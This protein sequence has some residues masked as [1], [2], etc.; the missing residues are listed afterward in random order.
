MNLININFKALKSIFR[1]SFIIFFLYS[2]LCVMAISY[3]GGLNNINMTTDFHHYHS[4]WHEH[5]NLNLSDLSVEIYNKK[6]EETD[7]FEYG[8]DWLPNPIYSIIALF[9]LT[10]FGNIWAIKLI[11][12]ILGCNYL[13][14][15]KKFFTVFINNIS[16]WKIN[17][18]LIIVCLNRW[19]IKESLGLGTMFL[20]SYFLI[21]GITSEKTFLRSLFFS[22]AI[23]V[24]PNFIIFFLPF[25]IA[26]FFNDYR[27]NKNLGKLSLSCICPLLIYP[28]YYFFVD[29]TYIGGP[30][31]LIFYSKGQGFDWAQEYFYKLIDQK[32]DIILPRFIEDK[33]I[34]LFLWDLNFSTFIKVIATDFGIVMYL[35]QIYVLKIFATLGFRFEQAFNL[36]LKG[37]WY[38]SELWTLIYSFF[39]SLPGFICS[40]LML[41]KRAPYLEIAAYLS[42][43][44][45]VF[46]T[47][48]FLGDPRYSLIVM[49]VI[50]FSI[51]RTIDL[52]TKNDFAQNIN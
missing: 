16:I 9:P 31:N 39:I 33:P 13:A 7:P 4:Y 19:F 10:I 21:M 12:F 48:L 41:I 52:I 20:C 25:C 36:P 29:S 35:L 32:T 50:I 28:F 43:I 38:L 15:L 3:S 5:T 49:P 11:G 1:S 18:L 37:G 40:F 30:L 47:S 2:F 45:Y 51:F 27:K 42:S 8:Y 46:G 26:I 34:D 14:R 17:F 44:I 23:A 24:R 22:L 6:L